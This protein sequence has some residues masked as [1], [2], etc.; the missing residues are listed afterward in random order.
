M[1]KITKIVLTMAVTVFSVN[2]ILTLIQKQ[3][4]KVE[5]KKNTDDLTDENLSDAFHFNEEDKILVA[6]TTGDGEID[7]I[8]LDTTGDGE[9]D[10]ILMDTTGDGKL[11]TVMADTT[12]DGM[13]DSVVSQC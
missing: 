10:T 2:L 6:D 11:D 7:T 3:Q 5:T 13:I 4:K 9:V 12:G 8:M 1:K